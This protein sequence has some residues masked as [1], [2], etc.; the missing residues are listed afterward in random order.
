M[1]GKIYHKIFESDMGSDF[2]D[3]KVT[4]NGLEWSQKGLERYIIV[5][6]GVFWLLFFSVMSSIGTFTNRMILSSIILTL[7]FKEKTSPMLCDIV[8]GHPKTVEFEEK[9]DFRERTRYKIL[10]DII[11]EGEVIESIKRHTGEDEK[12]EE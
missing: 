6:V 12:T 1:I 11:Y 5:N 8:K 3:I 7:Y 9:E 4:D 10:K 2:F